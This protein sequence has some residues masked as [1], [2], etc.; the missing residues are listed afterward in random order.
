MG[1]SLDSS[2]REVFPATLASP[3]KA[4]LAAHTIPVHSPST[5]QPTRTLPAIEEAV[6]EV[7]SVV[8]MPFGSLPDPTLYTPSKRAKAMNFSAGRFH[9]QSSR[10]R[11][12]T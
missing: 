4:I 3:V 12:T 10:N 9:L 8:P 7:D 11:V 2:N 1:P 6:D 5:P